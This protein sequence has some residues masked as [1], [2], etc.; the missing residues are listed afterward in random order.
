MTSVKPAI[1]LQF[2]DYDDVKGVPT[3]V[4]RFEWHERHG[5]A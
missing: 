2:S 3:P 5:I 4:L 1:D